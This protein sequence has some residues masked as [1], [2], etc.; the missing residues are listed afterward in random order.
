MKR[1]DGFEQRE[2]LGKNYYK[3]PRW[4]KVNKLRKDN[5]IPESNGLVMKIRAD[6]AL[7]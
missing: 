2:R 7:E 5:K 1:T 6:F 3:D 4:K